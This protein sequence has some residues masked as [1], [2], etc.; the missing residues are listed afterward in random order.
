[1]DCGCEAR[2]EVRASP[3]APASSGAPVTL[4]KL[5]AVRGMVYERLGLRV[6]SG[7]DWSKLSRVNANFENQT[8]PESLRLL[9]ERSKPP[10]LPHARPPSLSLASLPR[11]RK[12]KKRPGG[13]RRREYPFPLVKP[14]LF[15]AGSLRSGMI[16]VPGE[17]G[18]Q[19]A[20]GPVSYSLSCQG[21]NFARAPH[22]CLPRVKGSLDVRR[23]P[24]AFC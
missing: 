5:P 3:P 16:W 18:T 7:L 11:C 4:P 9:S 23:S 14:S 10:R 13:G 24:V 17:S 2:V 21:Q 6:G 12:S 8:L 19:E 1:M 22:S 20:A 15:K